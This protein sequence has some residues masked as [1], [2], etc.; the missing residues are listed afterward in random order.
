MKYPRPAYMDSSVKTTT[1][2][3]GFFA[4]TPVTAPVFDTPISR[5]ENF[6][7][8]ARRENPL[9]VPV[10][11]TDIQLLQ[12]NEQADEKPGNPGSQVGPR[13]KNP[14]PV[15]Y[16]FLDPFGNS[17]TWEATAGGAMLT[18]GT[19]V[20]EDIC[21]WEK[22][23]K[24]PKFDDWSFRETAEK[25]MKEQYDP[26]KVMHINIYQ[27]LTE[28]L[29]AF[30][31]GYG[32]GMM[33]LAEEPEAC[34]D[35]FWR[36]SQHLIDF[37]D[38]MDNLYPIEYVTWHDDYGTERDTFFSEKMMEELVFEPTKKLTDHIKSKGKILELHSCGKI[39]RFMPY[40]IDMGV[41][42]I[43]LQPRANDMVKMKE[44][45]GGKIGFNFPL[46]GML[47][48]ET[49]T[50]EEVI[51]CVRDSVDKYAKG[52]GYLPLV[53][54]IDPKEVWTIATELYAYSREFYE[55]QK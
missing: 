30:V 20:V 23:I 15:N 54:G 55:N 4:A 8:A 47:P 29:I 28:M 53:R 51:K 25:F 45:Y 18:P 46:D 36:F 17:W 41:D 6:L 40:I 9:W 24:F 22:C 31:G 38:Y 32:E 48:G 13:F 3:T 26:E 50:D 11:Y 21:D 16:N 2:T 5:R 10:A 19:K 35:F 7:R 1:N 12:A 27:G 33:A 42:L 14:S 37:F 34:K 39:E 52:G 43:W 44:I 49:Y